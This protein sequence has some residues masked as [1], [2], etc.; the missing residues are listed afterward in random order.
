LKHKETVDVTRDKRSS[1]GRF[2]P[3]VCSTARIDQHAEGCTATAFIQGETEREKGTG[4]EKMNVFSFD[5]QLVAG[6]ESC[7]SLSAIRKEPFK[8]THVSAEE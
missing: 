8:R 3:P 5:F 4:T 2:P 7:I 1:S 6:T